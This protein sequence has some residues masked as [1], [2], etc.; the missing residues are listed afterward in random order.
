LLKLID[1]EEILCFSSDY[2]HWD[3]DD[4]THVAQNLPEAW[5]SKVFRENAMKLF[6]WSGASEV[7]DDP[8]LAAGS[9]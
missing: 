3:T 5:R 1:A 6:G 2:P 4:V 8:R 7:G 9:R